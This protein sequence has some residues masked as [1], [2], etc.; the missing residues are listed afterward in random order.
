MRYNML[1]IITQPYYTIVVSLYYTIQLYLTIVFL[2][3]SIYIY[4]NIRFFYKKLHILY[5]IILYKK[6]KNIIG[7]LYNKNIIGKSTIECTNVFF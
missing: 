3:S 7:Q 2:Y 1:N 6:L 4:I 5:Y